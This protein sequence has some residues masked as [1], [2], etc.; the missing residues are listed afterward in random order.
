MHARSQAPLDFWLWLT[1]AFLVA[2]TAAVGFYAMPPI[3]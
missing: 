3:P 2:T 1:V